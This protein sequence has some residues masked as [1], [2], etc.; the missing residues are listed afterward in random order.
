MAIKDFFDPNTENMKSQG[1]KPN[2]FIKLLR[3]I[4][5]IIIF[6]LR[7]NGK[8]RWSNEF[9]QLLDPHLMLN[10]VD[11]TTNLKHKLWE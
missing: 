5:N 8:N 4:S 9:I 7:L 1:F 3:L 11:K 6:I 10:F 2:F